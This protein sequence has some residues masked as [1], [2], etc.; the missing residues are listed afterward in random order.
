M[1]A[2]TET[3]LPAPLMA[4]GAV[5]AIVPQSLEEMWRVSTL[6]IRAGMAPKALVDKKSAVEAQ[7][8]VAIAIMAGAE[9][10]L[11]PW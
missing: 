8:S 4:G 2:Q 3:K 10:G 7:S 9:L 1:N 6:V 11:P 5:T